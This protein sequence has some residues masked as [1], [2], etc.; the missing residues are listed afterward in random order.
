MA[1][2][3]DNRKQYRSLPLR[4]HINMVRRPRSSAGRFGVVVVS[5][6]VVLST[7]VK[8]TAQEPP[9]AM[10]E[11]GPPPPEMAKA[12]AGMYAED[13]GEFR[14]VFRWVDASGDGLVQAQE[15]AAFLD[16]NE[17]QT[18]PNK[19]QLLR[20]EFAR[21][22]AD[23]D[24]R[25]EFETEY[26]PSIVVAAATGGEGASALARQ[27]GSLDDVTALELEHFQDADGDGD[28]GL[29]VDEYVKRFGFGDEAV[30]I[31]S[32]ADLDQGGGLSVLEFARAGHLFHG[33]TRDALFAFSSAPPP[34]LEL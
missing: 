6:V 8:V 18:S 5:M 28:G 12:V 30:R 9:P 10:E 34:R 2:P 26:L 17:K 22:D 21:L 32:Q 1:I 33:H 27:E 20:G 19:E 25:L 14:D 3:N 7:A 24:G 31:V 11:L 23:Q 16:R 15:L 4:P 29:S 13:G